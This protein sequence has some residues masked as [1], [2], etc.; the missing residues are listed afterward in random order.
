MTTRIK[1]G[2]EL[3]DMS[4][5]KNLISIE[6]DNFNFAGNFNSVT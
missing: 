4:L 5:E 1:G 2:Q 6:C 3:M